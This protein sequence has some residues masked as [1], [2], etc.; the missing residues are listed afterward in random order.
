MKC[1]LRNII[2][3]MLIMLSLGV[4]AQDLHFSQFYAVP[5]HLNPATTGAFKGSYR[6]DVINKDQWRSVGRSYQTNGASLD[7]AIPFKYNLMGI[8]FAAFQ[9]QSGQGALTSTIAMLSTAYHFAIGYDGINDIAIGANV[10]YTQRSVMTD[11]LLFPNQYTGNYFFDPT[12]S[13]GEDIGSPST[14]FL[15]AV[16][17]IHWFYSPEDFP[18]FFTG[19]SARN[20]LRP[21]DAFQTSDYKDPIGFNFHFASSIDLDKKMKIAPK[22]N[23]QIQGKGREL[24]FGMEMEKYM[25]KTAIEKASIFGGAYYRVADAIIIVGGADVANIRFAISYDFTTSTLSPAN[26]SLGG[27]EISFQYKGMFKNKKGFKC[28]KFDPTY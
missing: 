7:F 6:V 10:S 20:I 27:T 2:A 25:V 8:G 3:I 5:Y 19:F 13:N 17:G 24:I 1:K 11:D 14:M 22:M 16:A 9:D 12:S 28:P 23:A 18:S 21:V 15:N 4:T 26:N